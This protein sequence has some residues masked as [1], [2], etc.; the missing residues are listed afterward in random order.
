MIVSCNST[1]NSTGK[2]PDKFAQIAI[3]KAENGDHA[4]QYFLASYY[5][6]GKRGLPKDK[7]KAIYWY[8]KSATG[9]NSRS[10]NNLAVI[11][12]KSKNLEEAVY[13]YKKAVSNNNK[14]AMINLGT[15][16]MKGQGVNK[17]QKKGYELLLRSAKLKEGKAQRMLASSYHYGYGT[18]LD[19]NE[20]YAWYMT[21]KSNGVNVEKFLKSLPKIGKGF[22]L[23]KAELLS[24]KYKNL[25]GGAL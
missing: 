6:D 7:N 9:G 22:E 11:F 12:E 20:A 1:G 24:E 17:D 21:A 18:K 14:V 3:E 23:S 15:L 19:Y 4:A 5:A 10:Q 25:Y 13:W 16:Y 8:Q 2:E